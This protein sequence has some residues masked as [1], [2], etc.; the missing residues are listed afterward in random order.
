MN[1]AGVCRVLLVDD[2]ALV[3]RGLAALLNGSGAYQ[4]TGEAGS[5]ASAITLA[6]HIEANI[7]IL[8]LGLPDMNGLEVVQYL[9]AHKPQLGIIIL[10]MYDDAPFVIRALHCGVKGYVLKQ[11]LE[12]ELFTA[13]QAVQQGQR[14]LSPVLSSKLGDDM[15]TLSNPTN[16]STK[17][18]Q[19]ELE[20]LHHLALG[21]TTQQVATALNISWHTANRHRANVMHK[22]G[23][24]NQIEL[25]CNAEKH[26]LIPK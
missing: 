10:S 6:Q 21:H 3:R 2:H 12:D 8:D 25:L 16:P 19:R 15:L 9:S 4:V 26:G 7:M 20:V 22:L 14:Y 17:L 5:G 18:T 24:H 23:A 13:L 1:P 11:S